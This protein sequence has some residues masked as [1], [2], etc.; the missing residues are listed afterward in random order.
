MK[1]LVIFSDSHGNKAGINKLFPIMNEAD[2]IICLGDVKGETEE[3]EILYG[4]KFIRVRG[5]C[6]FDFSLKTER[7]IEIE[8]LKILITHGHEYRVKSSLLDLSARARELSVGTALY[9]HTHISAISEENG[10]S[11]INPGALGGHSTNTYC[12]A[13]ITGGR[14]LA[15]I[16]PLYG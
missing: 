6:D 4:D 7:V 2:Y 15:R 1:K 10:L 9:G 16:V 12:Y 5:N 11:L 8:G 13:V 3:L 14:I